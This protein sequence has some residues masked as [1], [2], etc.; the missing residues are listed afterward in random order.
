MAAALALVGTPAAGAQC[1]LTSVVVPLGMG[2]GET[3][4]KADDSFV[5][6]FVV[7]YLAGIGMGPVLGG[8]QACADWVAACLDGKSSFQLTAIV[9]KYLTDHPDEWSNAAGTLVWNAALRPCLPS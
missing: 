6:S 2:S 5:E 1:E 9:R 8:T 3:L 4:V 7:G